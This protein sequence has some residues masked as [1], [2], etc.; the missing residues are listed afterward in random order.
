MFQDL[1]SKW[2]LKRLASVTKDIKSGFASGK[3]D[4]NGIVQLRM[5]NVDIGGKINLEKTLKVPIP[6]N[7]EDYLLQNGDVLFNNTNSVDL[8]GKT[9]IF[10]DEIIPCTYSNHLTRIRGDSTKVNQKWILYNLISLWKKGIFFRICNRHVGQAGITSK[11][12][13]NLRIPVPP[14]VEQRGIVEVLGTV[15]E[16][17]RLTDAVIER[18]EELKRGLIQRLLTRGIGHTEYKKTPIGNMPKKWDLL[19][20]GDIADVKGGKRL[21]KGHKFVEGTSKHPYIRVIDMKNGEVEPYQLKYLSD[22]TFNII[23]R[24]II[25]IQD[26]YISIA[27]TIGLCGIIS[28]E[29]DGANLTENAAKITNIKNILPQ[30]LSYYLNSPLGQKQIKSLTGQTSQ[31]KL[32]LFRIRK[33]RVPIPHNNEQEK[34]L[35]IFTNIDKKIETEKS[36]EKN[37][38]SLKKGL[39]Q[40]LLSGNIRVELKGDGLHRI[41]DGREANN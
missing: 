36:M 34:I 5:N 33:I 4:D 39:M 24:Y 41:G 22:E 12:I 17:I 28:R 16:C 8:I 7:I 25:N 29:L 19:S 13:D 37:L 3:R 26:V 9:S 40:L 31:P 21:P 6:Q 32:A 14:L 20:I 27:G 38:I 11:D 2:E 30:F 15:D 18:A 1:P 35:E 23:K 10:N